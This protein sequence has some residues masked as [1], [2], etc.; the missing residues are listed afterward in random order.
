MV[1]VTPEEFE[2][3]IV[4]VIPQLQQQPNGQSSLIDKDF[5]EITRLLQAF[6]KNEWSLRPRIYAVLRMINSV[7]SIGAFVAEGLLD[8]SIPF[9]NRTLPTSF[10]NHAARTRFLE[11]QDVV[12]NEAVVDVER[13]GSRHRHFS[14]DGDLYFPPLR[15]LGRGGSATVQL[16]RSKHSLQEYARKRLARGRTFQRDKKAIA[17]FERE[18]GIYKRLSHSHLIQYVGSY[19][20]PRYVAILL[21]PVA[22]CNLGE[23]LGRTPFPSDKQSFLAQSYGCLTSALAYVHE[24]C[25][26]HK[27]IK[28]SNILIHRQNIL[29]AD[30]GAAL[31]FR[32]RDGSTTTGVPNELTRRYCSPEVAEHAVSLPKVLA[33]L[34]LKD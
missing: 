12:F 14:R 15:E 30:F 1:T 17:N 28:P 16:V 7:S 34:G 25:V 13:Q 3:A 11:L 32:D 5:D 6:G 10:S 21:T 18:L 27:D 22:D 33:M 23:L 31:D 9:T 4:A 19:T 26:R 20:D 8:I 2:A 29:L 24:N